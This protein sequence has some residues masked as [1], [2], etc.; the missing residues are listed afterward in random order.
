[1]KVYVV[2]PRKYEFFID[3]ELALV[4]TIYRDVSGYMITKKS[5]PKTYLSRDKISKLQEADFDKL[6][7]MDKLKPTQLINLVRELKKEVIDRILLILEIF[8][9]HAGSREALLQ[10]ELARLR[11]TLPLVK[12]A[13]R[14]T[15][16]GELH[17]FLGAGRYGYEKYYLMLKRRETRIKK[18]I[19]KIRE[20]RSI[21][22]RA[23]L[24][25]GLP[26]VVIVGYTGAGKTTLF[27]TITGLGQPVGSTPFTTI[28]PK[29]HRVK[30]RDLDF[31]VIDTVG[32]IRDIPPEIIDSFYATLEEV[33][34]AD[35]VIN[36]VDSS[37]KPSEVIKEIEVSR[38]VL[39]KLGVHNK[40]I[41]IALNKIDKSSHLEEILETVKNDINDN[42]KTITLSCIKGLNIDVLLDLIYSEL[43][44]KPS[45]YS[46]GPRIE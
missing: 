20:A 4:K 16:L 11:Y 40:P 46:E 35:L 28:T 12:E 14:Y 39:R 19:E 22:R 31:I 18:E 10:V 3:E 26:H 34:E 41:I 21:R 23:R 1:M 27:N 5:S 45:N 13:I 8:A 9:D 2:I 6:I 7:L 38:E 29:A 43:R 24:E 44:N 33:V 36:V 25:S 15:K 17:G 37:K 30:Y 32:F 42:E